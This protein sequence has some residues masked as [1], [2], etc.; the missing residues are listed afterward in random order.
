MIY[1]NKHIHTVI[2]TFFQTKA[3]TNKEYKN[4][5]HFLYTYIHNYV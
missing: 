2:L 5:K 3:C 1:I 4:K